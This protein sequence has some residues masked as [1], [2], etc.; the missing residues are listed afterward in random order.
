MLSHGRRFPTGCGTHGIDSFRSFRTRRKFRLR[1]SPHLLAT[2]LSLRSY[3]RRFRLALGPHFLLFILESSGGILL[4]LS[5]ERRFLTGCGTHILSWL[6]PIC[7]P[8]YGLDLRLDA[9]PIALI[10][11]YPFTLFHFLTTSSPIDYRNFSNQ[12]FCT[13]GTLGRSSRARLR[14][15]DNSVIR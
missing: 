8:S 4:L 2:F 10:L 5:Y 9:G 3:G 1:A 15:L 13:G 14:D 7:D 12:Y 11:F 6:I